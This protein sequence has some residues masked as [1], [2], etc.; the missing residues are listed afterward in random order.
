[1]VVLTPG[2]WS[3]GLFFE[4]L[5][6]AVDQGINVVRGELKAVSVGNRVR[7]TR[8]DTV[9]A[10]NAARI[11]DIVNAGVALPRGDS[12]GIRIFGGFDVDAIRRARRSAEKASNALF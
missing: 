8:F 2:S 7:R 9:T 11:I 3:N 4:E 6:L 12:A 1:M 10:E 5:F